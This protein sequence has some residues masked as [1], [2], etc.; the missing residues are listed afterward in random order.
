MGIFGEFLPV[1]DARQRFAH[2]HFR[3]ACVRLELLS[4]LLQGIEERGGIA[5]ASPAMV[6][7][8]IA[9]AADIS[10]N[11]RWCYERLTE[12]TRR[13]TMD[14]ARL[15]FPEGGRVGESRAGR[16]ARAEIPVDERLRD[17]GR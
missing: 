13:V 12:T 9:A 10:D 6:S 8:A 11:L 3:A 5:E 4:R 1:D 15:D 14:G 7:E 17:G 2:L 16:D